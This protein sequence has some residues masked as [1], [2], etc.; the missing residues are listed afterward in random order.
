VGNPPYQDDSGNS[1]KGHTLWDKFIKKSFTNLQDNGYLVFVHPA[2]WR[3]PNHEMFDI[4]KTKQILHLSIHDEKD[5]LK[6]F[7][8]NTRY[9]WYV[10]ENTTCYKETEIET[11]DKT[12]SLVD[13]SKLHII[14][15]FMFDEIISYTS[16]DD[17]L[18][19]IKERSTYGTDKKHVSE[20]H[21]NVFQYPLVNSVNR[22]NKPKFRYSSKNTDGHFGV[23]KVI[24]GSGATG[25][26]SDPLGKY[27]LTEWCTG[28]VDEQLKHEKILSVLNSKKFR[29]I[30]LACSI[31]KAE[32]N[33]KVL[34][35][36]RKDFFES[37]DLSI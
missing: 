4:L 30:V 29:Q 14:P 32:I 36:F 13:I 15:N 3:Q 10:L 20:T 35:M 31:G 9:D 25:F 21:N 7:Q 33:T 5:G 12:I 28:I 2:G 27:G 23:P 6:T 8:C 24:F 26:I 19:I 17:K 1:G 16:G 11:Q 37:F 34:K 18:V 22:A